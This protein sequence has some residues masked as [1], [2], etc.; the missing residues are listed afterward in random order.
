MLFDVEVAGE[1]CEVVPVA[2]LVV[3]V[4]LVGLARLGPA[5]GA[6][7][8]GEQRHDLADLAGVNAANRFAEAE[9]VAEAEAR[10]DRDVLL[11]GEFASLQHGAHAGG[12][13]GTRFFGEDVL[14]R[15]NRGPHVNRPKVR[16]RREQYDI[17]RRDHVLVGV[18]SGEA[19]LGFYCDLVGDF[20]FG[21]EVGEA[22][23]QP[24]L[25]GIGHGDELDVLV[26]GEGLDGGSGAAI[27]AADEPDANDVVT[28]GME[29]RGGNGSGRCREKLAAR[30][31]GELL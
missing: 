10:H 15:F 20:L 24:I 4:G 12:I 2:H 21:A 1:P 25:E 7:I 14:A 8:V 5:A 26:G 3:H 16:R 18:E 11:P 6:V 28:R 17:A 13:D 30:R 27:A 9:V 19:R 31:H 23:L 22:R 29:R